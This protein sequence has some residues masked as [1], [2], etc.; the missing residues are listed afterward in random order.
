MGFLEAHSQAALDDWLFLE[1]PRVPTALVR[2]QGS[3]S[4]A[5]GCPQL[6]SCCCSGQFLRLPQ[7][8][9]QGQRQAEFAN[10]L[11]QDDLKMRAP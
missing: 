2:C 6:L 3:Q 8:M 7:P 10:A 4:L 5:A 1:V 11:T 9:L